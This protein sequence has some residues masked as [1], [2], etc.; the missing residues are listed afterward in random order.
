MTANLL[1]ACIS[2]PRPINPK[3]N[4]MG[5]SIQSPTLDSVEF[6]SPNHPSSKTTTL[7]P[8]L[9]PYIYEYIHILLCNPSI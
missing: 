2:F 6:R 8:I 5:F 9:D 3:G 4:L 1:K 7:I